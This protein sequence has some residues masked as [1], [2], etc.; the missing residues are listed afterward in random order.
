M[1]PVPALDSEGVIAQLLV[2]GRAPHICAYVVLVRQQAL[3]FQ[4]SQYRRP[5]GQDLDPVSS[6]GAGGPKSLQAAED[7]VFCPV[8]QRRHRIGLVVEGD[9]VEDVLQVGPVHTAQSIADDD[10][11]V[12]GE[13]RVI[14]AA[15]GDD[16][17][18]G[19]AVTVALLEPLTLQRRATSVAA[20]R[21]PR[22]RM[23]PNAQMRSPS[24]WNPNIE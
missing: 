8:G 24:R 19:V 18:P 20:M 11:P 13:R 10:R 3:R 9:V 21:K 5:A 14:G 6:L 16:R 2:A 12:V 7:P 4:C 15:V 17:R 23:S 1:Q 22:P